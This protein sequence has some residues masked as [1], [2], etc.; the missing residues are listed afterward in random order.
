MAPE[1]EQKL[2]RQSVYVALFFAILGIV[3]GLAINS[4]VI[5]FDGLYSF[6]TVLLSSLSLVVSRQLEQ[7]DDNRFQFGRAILEPL[8]IALKSVG[9]ALMCAYALVSAVDDLLRGGVQVSA[10]WGMAYAV[11]STLACLLGWR[12]ILRQCREGSSELIRAEAEQWYMD[13][14]LSAAVLA[15]FAVS[16]LLGLS[17]YKQWTPYTD[18]LMVVIIAGFVV[19]TPLLMLVRA[20]REILMIA[21]DDELQAQVCH[22]IEEVLGVA[23]ETLV[24]RQTKIGRELII[25]VGMIVSPDRVLGTAAEQDELRQRLVDSLRSTGLQPWLTV[26]F[27]ADRKWL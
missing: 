19:R 23:A 26:S 6:V 8:V 3:W 27:S 5:I 1:L 16:F 14:M 20:S 13:M 9:I 22:A 4:S 21:P 12:Y 2:L 15:G 25:D 10:G 11:I 18:P 17:D 7:P 24:I